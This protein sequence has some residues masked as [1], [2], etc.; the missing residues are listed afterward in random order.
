MNAQSVFFIIFAYA[1]IAVFIVGFLARI[2]KYAVTPSPLKI[3]LTPA[4]VT[5]TGVVYRMAQEIGFFRSLFYSNKIIW[6]AGYTMH[7]ALAL[8]L[9]KHIRFFFNGIPAAITYISTYEL[10]IGFIFIAPLLFLFV[11][12]LAV[13]RTFYISIMTD[14][15]ILALFVLIAFTGI[16]TKY[17]V[18]TDIITVK[19]FIM[20]LV[21]FR[22]EAMPGDIIF[23][24]HFTL[25]MLLLVYFPFS[26]LMHAGGIFFSPTRNQ[27]DNPREVRHET[28][29]AAKG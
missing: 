26:K 22:P 14:F 19:S 2:W 4:P 11:M 18:R 29:W 21:N 25:V 3:A 6:L 9:I 16:I 20:G 13:D 7:I 10:Y 1:A 8:T 24:I 23:M 12:R 5:S 28:A 17:Y 27:I 15:I